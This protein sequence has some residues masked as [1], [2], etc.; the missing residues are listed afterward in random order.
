MARSQATTDVDEL[1][2]TV[3][4]EVRHLTGFDRVMVYRF[5]KDWHGEVIAESLSQGIET[6]L[7]LH[8][9][10]TDIPVQARV[11]YERNWL[12]MIKSAHYQPVPLMPGRNPINDQP[13]D[14]SDSV[15]RS[16]S[17]VHCEYL[18]NMG[19]EA[20][21]SISL[22]H[23]EKKLWGLVACHHRLPRLVPYDIRLACELVGQTV[24]LL[25]SARERLAAA[26]R[27][28]M[29]EPIKSQ[30]VDKISAEGRFT[31]GLA[32]GET[33]F[34]KVMGADGC[35]TILDGRLQCIGDAPDEDAIRN[36]GRWLDAN[37][38][39]DEFVTDSLAR[40]YPPGQV[41][42]AAASGV[43]SLPI[44]GS[45][46]EDRIF[47]FRKEIARY[48]KW[49]GAQSEIEEALG[50]KSNLSPRQ[51]FA[52][53]KTKVQDTSNPWTPQDVS[54]AKSIVREL[55]RLSL[56]KF[57][58][59]KRL[60]AQL[61]R[62]ARAKD[63]FLAT[64]S[65]ELRTPL[66]AILG[67]S[68]LLATSDVLT[69]E[70]SVVYDMIHRNALSQKHLIE[71][72]LDISRII[73]GKLILHVEEFSPQKAVEEV[74]STVASTA[75][76]KAVKVATEFDPSLVKMNGDCVRVQ[77]IVE[78]LLTNA[79]KFTPAGG[80]ITVR[81]RR[82]DSDLEIVVA[83]DGEGIDPAL[84]PEIFNRHQQDDAKACQRNRGLGL[85]LTIVRQLVE[86]H[87]GTVNADSAGKGKG[88][89]FTVRMPL[90]FLKVTEPTNKAKQQ[91]QSAP[92]TSISLADLQALIVDDDA[93][94]RLLTERILESAGAATSGVDNMES[95]LATLQRERFDLIISDINMPDGNGYDF[96]RLV[97]KLPASK[98]GHTPAIALTGYAGES[99]RQR[100]IEAGF[101]AHL[102]KPFSRH[103]MLALIADIAGRHG[104]TNSLS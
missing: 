4:E 23:D 55:E 29:L 22:L 84:L 76:D 97:R 37:S 82:L 71:D 54:T 104:S 51:S 33:D 44:A 60:N 28:E 45:G 62:E 95:A 38:R 26:K 43:L 65:H 8:F 100:A 11:L 61:R 102:G 91:P 41:Y 96:M 27:L 18:K 79:I 93:D 77:Q 15:L 88:A 78:N 83:D 32:A 21:M 89:T 47:C 101:N 80:H 50:Q 48:V 35:C 67:W 69:Q 98:G 74:L 63:E 2:Q 17:P 12:R 6:F 99:N 81:L 16:V 14:L 20:S 92:T 75:K 10:A 70:R 34:L 19:V 59:V 25:I 40:E 56:A 30:L 13:L 58:E 68:E 3:A 46:L 31:S 1:C 73:N 39:I 9:P 85:G 24:S 72:L 94:S 103:N 64:I 86:L 90:S 87:G 66:N 42:A 57:A 53:W 52:A 49:A 5:H 7:G 36:L